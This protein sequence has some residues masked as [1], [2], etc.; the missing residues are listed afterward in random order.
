MLRR[1]SWTERWAS[2]LVF[3][4]SSVIAV[5]LAVS[6]YHID[7][8]PTDSCFFYL[9]AARKFLQNFIVADM[10]YVRDGYLLFI[11]GKE[12][13]VMGIALLQKLLGDSTSLFPNILLLIISIFIST[14]ILFS[15][16]RRYFGEIPAL[17]G[18]FILMMSY[19]PYQ[20]ILMG[21]HPPFVLMNFLCAVFFIQ[22]MEK[23]WFSCLAGF[24]LGLMLFSSPTA[25]LCVPYVLGFWAHHL[26]ALKPKRSIFLSILWILAG[27]GTVMAYITLPDPVHYTRMFMGYLK[28]ARSG[29][30]F[31][32]T[33]FSGFLQL[34]ADFRGAGWPWIWRY[35]ALSQP[36]LLF[37]YIMA[38]TV[39][40]T[41]QRNK[42]IA[43]GLIVLSFSAPIAVEIVRAAQFGRNYFPFIFGEAFMV[44]L[45]GHFVYREKERLSR[46]KVNALRLGVAAMAAAYI[47][48][49]GWIFFADVWPSR[50]ASNKVYQW[51]HRRG[52]REVYLYEAFPRS[53]YAVMFINNPKYREPIF[54]KPIK[55][56]RDAKEGYI[57]I[58]PLT[59][60]HI[61]MDCCDRDFSRDP[62]LNELRNEGIIK[63]YIL[64]SFPSLASSRIW[65]QEAEICTYRD[66]VRK[67][68]TAEDR[69]WGRIFILDAG[70][71]QRE[72]FASR[73][74]FP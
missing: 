32:Y 51:L 25:A 14:N 7:F 52:I 15:V 22:R 26:Y 57:L 11:H 73:Q 1:L 37:I 41:H 18:T 72:F 8:F 43:L 56:I 40:W 66:L 42:G 12:A 69:S 30:D 74:H 70:K 61:W 31:S 33:D 48:F 71:L 29:S 9:P 6:T 44:A 28:S 35:F 65:P 39:V 50:M 4:L 19:W 54:L 13:L 59:G 21:A 2:R 27:M 17:A 55:T 63:T 36:I 16:F 24:F 62:Y 3:F 49:N 53:R 45:A 67:D 10:Y 23:P 5:S 58:P 60:K 38:C 64:A 20:Y 47:V 68:I 46:R 34:P